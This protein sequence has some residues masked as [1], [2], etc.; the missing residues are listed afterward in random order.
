[1]VSQRQQQVKN[2]R[3][4]QCIEAGIEGIRW[5]HQALVQSMD[6]YLSFDTVSY[7][8]KT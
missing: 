1:M 7:Y 8:W 4:T 2:L 3:S 5:R 6:N